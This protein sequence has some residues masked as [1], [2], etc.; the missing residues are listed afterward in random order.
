MNKKLF[1][2]SFFILPSVVFGADYQG[3]IY[4][5][6]YGDLI[7]NMLEGIRALVDNNGLATIFKVAMGVAFFVFN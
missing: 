3:T 7:K 5:W 1:L 2:L 4:T 6:G